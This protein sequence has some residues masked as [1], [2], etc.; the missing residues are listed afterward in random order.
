MTENLGLFLQRQALGFASLP[1]RL[2]ASSL[3]EAS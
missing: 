2:P 1:N 3:F